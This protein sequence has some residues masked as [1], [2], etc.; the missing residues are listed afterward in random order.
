MQL[1]T[2]KSVIL[3]TIEDDDVGPY[4]KNTAVVTKLSSAFIFYFCFKI[5]NALNIFFIPYNTRWIN[6]DA[7]SQIPWFKLACAKGS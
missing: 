2:L 5:I 1:L 3:G 7:N 6:L 4:H